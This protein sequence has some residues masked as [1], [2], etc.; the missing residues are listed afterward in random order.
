MTKNTKN[1]RETT[2]ARLTLVVEY[3][4]LPDTSDIE[5]LVEKAREYGAPVKAE[6]EIFKASKVDLL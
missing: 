4:A 3:E 5:E 1:V 6:L 2:V